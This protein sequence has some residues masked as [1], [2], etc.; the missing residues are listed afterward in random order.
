MR[1]LDKIVGWFAREDRLVAGSILRVGLGIVILS[2]YLLHYP[3][4]HYFWGP[5][6]FVSLE[7]FK[8]LLDDVGGSHSVYAL[9]D[10]P[11]VFEALFHAGLLCTLLFV[12]GVWARVT[13]VLTYVFTFSL[14]E[15]NSYVLDG[16]DNILIICLFFLLFVRTDRYLAVGAARRRARLAAPAA[17]PVGEGR[18]DRARAWLYQAGTVLHNAAL[19]AIIVQVCFLYLTS[20][21]YKVQ[22][23][24]WQSGVALYYVLRVQEF[25]WPGV[26]EFI[27][28]NAALVTAFT[29]LTVLEQVAY[30]FMLLNRYAKRISVFIVVQM[31]AGIALLM[32]LFS[33]ST[34]MITLQATAFRDHE[35]FGAFHWLRCRAAAFAEMLAALRGSLGR[36]LAPVAPRPAMA[37]RARAGVTVYYDGWC[38]RCTAIRAG[39]E[40]LD[41]LGLVSFRS[42]RDAGVEAEAG[43]A[44]ERLLARMHVRGRGGRMRSGAAAMAAMFARVP[45]LAPLWPVLALGSALGVGE[46]IYDFAASRRKVIPVGAC[47]GAACATGLGG[48]EAELAVR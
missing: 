18:L 9:S 32:G 22:G 43:V 23:Q 16:G 10:K 25:T 40:R 46:R 31:H 38:P 12:L 20:A 36:R 21:L 8:A 44:A 45:L 39:V 13:A 7:M 34:V 41:W 48:P 26:A 35:F 5:D 47:D 3:Y 6:A 37:V 17:E 1:L 27:W 29:Y 33:F 30:P 14:W 42:V 19:I 28:R 11:W 4:R 2:V 15:R 24:M